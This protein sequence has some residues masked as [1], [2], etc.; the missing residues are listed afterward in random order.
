MSSR[1]RWTS[2]VIQ[3]KYEDISII[4]HLLHAFLCTI[5]HKCN[6]ADTCDISSKSLPLLHLDNVANLM[7]LIR[8]FLADSSELSICKGTCTLA[9]GGCLCGVNAD[10]L[11]TRSRSSLAKFKIRNFSSLSNFAFRFCAFK[12]SAYASTCRCSVSKHLAM[13]WMFLR[14]TRSFAKLDQCA[15]KSCTFSLNSHNWRISSA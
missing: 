11:A 10:L 15:S 7:A 14:V 8:S 3:S 6:Q 12:S 1:T 4:S 2:L 13:I 9:G 5:I